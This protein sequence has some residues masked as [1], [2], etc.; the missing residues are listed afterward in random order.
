MKTSTLIISLFC[1]IFSVA[2]DQDLTK[3]SLEDLLSLE[4]TT[5][6]KKAQSLSESPAVVSVITKEMLEQFQLRKLSDV[7]NYVP[8]FTQI[9]SYWKP[10]I[11]IARGV[12][13]TL[14]N[15]KILMLINGVPDYDAASMEFFLDSVPIEVVE[16]IEVIRG[17]GSTLY[18]TNAFAGVINIITRTD[19]GKTA[20]LAIG[21]FETIQTG[22]YIA[23]DA[24]SL[25]YTVSA[26]IRE[27]E[28]YTKENVL[29]EG[30][31]L[32]SVTYERDIQNLFIDLNYKGLRMT[33]GHSY[34]HFGK[35]GPVPRH[36][37][38]QNG[39][40]D[41]GK[42]THRKFFGNLTYEHKWGNLDSKWMLHYDDTDKQTEVGDFA[43]V[44][45][46]LGALEPER[47][48]ESSY[49][50]FGGN[51]LQLEWQG[52][53]SIRSLNFST[54]IVTERREVKNLADLTAGL[55]GEILVRGSTETL[56]FTITDS[57]AYLQVDGKIQKVGYVAGVRATRL[58][59]DKETYT[60]PR[61][62]VVFPI[63]SSY[64]K[65]LYGEA[66]RSPGPQEQYYQ[67]PAIIYGPDLFNR[68]LKPESVRTTEVVMDTPVG[69]RHKLQLNA[70]HTEVSD[71]I[72]RRP[73]T[74]EEQEILGN[75][76]RIYDNLGIQETQG[77]E[78]EFTGISN[79]AKIS[80]YFFNA[81]YKEGE[82]DSGSDILFLSDWTANFGLNLTPKE[83]LEWS[84]FG[85]FVGEREG[86]LIDGT[87]VTVGSYFVTDTNLRF[88]LGNHFEAIVTIHNLLDETYTYPEFVRR[89]LAEVP[90]GPE[91]SYS[92]SGT[93]RF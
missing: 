24:G 6:S 9:D 2:S 87:Q 30:G 26:N 29:D 84:I 35:F 44:Y 73:S 3:L 14:Y 75:A 38:G 57:G 25:S 82:E 13:P 76:G 48:P 62:G 77:I 46:S 40:A 50:R 1:T 32:D 56:P 79:S 15:D 4:V 64:L 93:F 12:R 43:A 88:D 86:V 59:I 27:D 23:D 65:L 51:I 80:S 36:V 81:A 58:G 66:F 47:I 18:G 8:G 28:G 63:R 31:A 53:F 7:L 89:R 67:V 41:G 10:D 83:D 49:Y 34:Q 42:A 17:P 68:S 37:W 72:G 90:G 20:T 60:T 85:R 5:V 70:F 22:L 74:P 39:N 16:R 21:S 78:L 61:A 71:L 92:V 54:G 11:A 69:S 55:N 33:L 45:A 91:R 52:Q 19:H